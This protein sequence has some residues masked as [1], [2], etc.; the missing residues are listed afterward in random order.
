MSAVT[1]T[2]HRGVTSF[3]LEAGVLTITG[4]G[5]KAEVRVGDTLEYR[6]AV[7]AFNPL[8]GMA[9]VDFPMIGGRID[10]REVPMGELHVTSS[11]MVETYKI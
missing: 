6:A 5:G 2:G 4:P 11:S 3:S 1:G 10:R 9:V 7:V 8:T